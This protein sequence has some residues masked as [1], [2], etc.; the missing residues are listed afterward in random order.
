[1]IFCTK[2]NKLHLRTKPINNKENQTTERVVCDDD[3]DDYIFGSELYAVVEQLEN[4]VLVETGNRL[5]TVRV[6]VDGKGLV[7]ADGG[8]AGCTSL[9][10]F[11]L[12][13]V[14]AHEEGTRGRLHTSGHGN[15]RFVDHRWT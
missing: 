6:E 3:F 10:S 7:V 5:G 8:G 13:V 12:V 15:P 2:Q 1:L 9:G 4:L 11:E 14:G